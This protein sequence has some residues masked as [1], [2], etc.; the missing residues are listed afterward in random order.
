MTDTNKLEALLPCPFCGS[1]TPDIIEHENKTM[2]GY[3]TAEIC[4][5][6]CDDVKMHGHGDDMHEALRY[7]TAEWNTRAP[8][9]QQPKY[10]EAV[11]KEY[12]WKHE[13]AG[14]I[15]AA[16]QNMGDAVIRAIAQIRTIELPPGSYV[17]NGKIENVPHKFIISTNQ[18]PSDLAHAPKVWKREELDDIV[19]AASW[20]W[21]ENDDQPETWLEQAILNALIKAGA[22]SVEDKPDDEKGE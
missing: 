18:N 10:C 21:S 9:L 7:A 5:D 1:L 3:T 16:K 8:S 20:E 22:I 2:G 6:D 15:C 14:E 13:Q 19:H 12:C 17:I 4:C 11:G